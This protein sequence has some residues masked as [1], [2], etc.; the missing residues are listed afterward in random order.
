MAAL[1]HYQGQGGPSMLD[2]WLSHTVLKPAFSGMALLLDHSALY[3]M[4]QLT[5]HLFFYY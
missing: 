3:C 2:A 5:V 4:Q 1:E